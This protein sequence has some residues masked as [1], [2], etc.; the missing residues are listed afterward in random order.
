MDLSGS[1]NQTISFLVLFSVFGFFLHYSLPPFGKDNKIPRCWQMFSD[2]QKWD[3]TL[4]INGQGKGQ[5]RLHSD[6]CSFWNLCPYLSQHRGHLV[7]PCVFY[8]KGDRDAERVKNKLTNKTHLAQINI[9]SGT[10]KI[11]AQLRLSG[12]QPAPVTRANATWEVRAGRQS[13]IT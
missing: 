9:G 12:G 13:G 2:L 8:R 4:F 1:A 7:Q 10:G 11:P 6:R 5:N 3:V